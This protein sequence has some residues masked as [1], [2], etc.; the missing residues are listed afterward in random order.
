MRQK[1]EFGILPENMFSRPTFHV[2]L[3][4]MFG[5]TASCSDSRHQSVSGDWCPTLCLSRGDCKTTS[6]KVIPWSE[7]LEQLSAHL[8]SFFFV[9]SHWIDRPLTTLSI[10]QRWQP[11]PR[12]VVTQ[13]AY[14]PGHSTETALLKMMN[15]ILH[16][17]DN[18]D[19]TV[20]ILLDLSPAFDTIDHNILSK[21]WAPLRNF[22]Y[23][24]GSD[25]TFAIELRL[26]P[27][28]TN[29]HIQPCSTLAFSKALSWDLFYSFCTQNLL[30]HSFDDTPFLTSLSQMTPSCT[31]PAVQIK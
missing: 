13:S 5:A 3:C 1:H 28:T 21:T 11:L 9:K 25:P 2:P 26:L 6:E 24:S 17:L 19:V 18:G 20:V 23:T 30:L 29:F 31:I 10:P 27:S 7:H 15:D 12:L 8:Q 4:W 16:A 22:W 14:R